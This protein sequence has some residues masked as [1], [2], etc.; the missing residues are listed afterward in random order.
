MAYGS[1]IFP[2]TPPGGRETACHGYSG[3]SMSVRNRSVRGGVSSEHIVQFF[4]TDESRAQNVAAFLAQGYAA[5]EPLVIAAR[6]T[7]WPAMMENLELFG[8]PVQNA[9]AEGMLIVKDA[10]DLVRRLT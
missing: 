3:A 7:N 1:L 10:H 8:V 4:D 9:I 6:P 2:A 5:A